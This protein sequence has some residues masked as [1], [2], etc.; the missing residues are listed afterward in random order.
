MDMVGKVF[1]WMLAI[2]AVGLG[3]YWIYQW[4][5]SRPLTEEDV[6]SIAQK[7]AGIVGDTKTELNSTD[8]AA[9][10]YDANKMVPLST[11]ML[12]K[13]LLK[14]G[15]SRQEHV[16]AE[17]ILLRVFQTAPD[18]Y[19]SAIDGDPWTDQGGTLKLGTFQIVREGEIGSVEDMLSAFNGGML[20]REH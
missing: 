1:K 4:N 7:I 10:E 16:A 19:P 6:T 20:R 17:I 14:L 9:V 5:E 13:G 3:A 2:A 8:L 11:T 12:T 15:N 18:K